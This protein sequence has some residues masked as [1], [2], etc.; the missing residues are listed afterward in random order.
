MAPCAVI[1]FGLLILPMTFE[2]STVTGRGSFEGSSRRLV[3][4]FAI[5]NGDSLI[6]ALVCHMTRCAIHALMIALIVWK[7]ARELLLNNLLVLFWKRVYVA[8]SQTRA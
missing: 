7:V 1:L 8:R 2:A 6:C 3:G 4:R 5:P